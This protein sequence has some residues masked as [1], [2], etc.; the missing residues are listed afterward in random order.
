LGKAL[1]GAAVFLALLATALGASIWAEGRAGAAPSSSLAWELSPLPK[2]TVAPEAA[3]SA[4]TPPPCVAPDEWVV[5]LVE[6]GDT[7][8]GL[9]QHYGT[10]VVSLQRVNC[11][12]SD[13]ILIGQALRVPGPPSSGSGAASQP[14]PLSAAATSVA[15]RYINIILMGADKRAG[16]TTWRTDTLIVVSVDT[17]RSIVR[18]LSIPRDLWVD[19]PGHGY[20]RINT[21]DEWGELAETGSGPDVVK[22][23][24]SKTLGIPIQYFFRLDFAGFT[25]IIDAAGGVD[26]DVECPLPDIEVTPGVQHMDGETALLYARSRITTNDFD[27]ARRQRKVLMALWG[28]AKSMD[29]LPRLP[30]LWLAMRGAFETDMPLS[31]VVALA[32]LALQLSPN[33]LFS[34]S[35]GPWQVENWVTPG[36][37]MVLLPRQDEI[38]KLL[39]SFYGP[40]DLELLDKTSR[41]RVQILNGSPNGQCTPLAA[42]AL[43]WAGLQVVGTGPADSPSYPQSQ[44]IVYNAEESVAQVV[45]QQLDLLPEALQYQPDASSDVDIRV[46]LGADYDPCAAQ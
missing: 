34:Q 30:G 45:A 11:L 24:V 36:G 23:T 12:A 29:I 15:E 4:V 9:G 8:Y 44:V 43:T 16:E 19:I 18:L 21:A 37:A 31:Q 28:K 26:V 32:P 40:I 42:S 14:T 38:Q 27:R 35:I 20:D 25:K 1:I 46:I 22:Q 33:R 5:H 7:L 41:T 10:D 6:Q 39:D 17:E 3:A 2:V 13:T